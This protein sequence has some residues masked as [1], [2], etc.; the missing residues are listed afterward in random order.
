M[1]SSIHRV[2]F[3][4][5]V[6]AIYNF[7]LWGMDKGSVKGPRPTKTKSHSIAKMQ[8]KIILDGNGAHNL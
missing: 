7:G 8:H 3:K 4:T 5:A 1:Q 2:G 6:T